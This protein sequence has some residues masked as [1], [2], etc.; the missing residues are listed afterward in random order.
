MNKDTNGQSDRLSNGHVNEGT[1][2]NFLKAAGITGTSAA[3]AGCSLSGGGGGDGTSFEDRDE[4]RL[5]VITAEEQVIGQSIIRSVEMAVNDI[6]ESGGIAGKELSLHIGDSKMDPNQAITAYQNLV[7]QQNIDMLTGVWISEVGM[8]L[9]EEAM[10]EQMIFNATA[11][12]S[13]EATAQVRADYER[14]KY[15]FRTQ[16]HTLQM[17]EWSKQ[18][19]E[20]YL[21]GELGAKR[22]GLLIEDALWSGP[23]GDQIKQFLN[24]TSGVELVFHERPATDVSEYGPIL[25]DAANADPDVLYTI[26][27]HLPGTTF[28]A[29]WQQNKYDFLVDGFIA[30]TMQFNYW[31]ATQGESNYAMSKFQQG[32]SQ[33]TPTKTQE[34]LDAQDEENA[35]GPHWQSYDAV[36]VLAQALES[37]QTLDADELVSTLEGISHEGVGGVTEYTPVDAEHPHN[38]KM[39]RDFLY[40]RQIQWQAIEGENPI[41]GSGFPYAIWPSYDEFALIDDPEAFASEAEGL[42]FIERGEYE[43]PPWVSL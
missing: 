1:R 40:P 13:P 36:G 35:P 21:M 22:F 11:M 37:A 39:G 31:S 4:I 16:I 2:R 18:Y 26:F 15:F 34:Y 6:N 24:E 10:D 19:I 29:P 41:S 9:L 3:L 8:T 33:Q 25:R 42:P 28:F 20:E 5:G 32:L 38:V 27:S 30:S 12:G 14:Y 17:A 23:Y 7:S 43:S